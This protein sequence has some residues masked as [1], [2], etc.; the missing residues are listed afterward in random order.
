MREIELK[1]GN[2]IKCVFCCVKTTGRVFSF[3]L[4]ARDC[5]GGKKNP[6]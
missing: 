1:F 3:F 4:A 6:S 2:K 5:P